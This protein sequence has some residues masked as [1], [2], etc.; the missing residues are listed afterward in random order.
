[1][2]D[3]NLLSILV[4][5]WLSG[6]A[7]AEP[8]SVQHQGLRLNGELQLADGQALGDGVVVL[9]HG[10][11]AHNRME[12]I[13]TLQDLL[14]EAGYNTLSINLSLSEDNRG[15]AM[16]DCASDHRHRLEDAVGE[17]ATWMAWLEASGGGPMVLVAHSLGGNQ[18]ARYALR[19]SSPQLRALV[20]LAPPN[21]DL[22]AMRQRNQ[23]AVEQ[24]SAALERGDPDALQ[25]LPSFLHCPESQVSAASVISYLHGDEGIS[26]PTLIARLGVPT[27]V[28]VGTADALAPGLEVAVQ[29]LVEAGKAELLLV[30]DADHFFR[31]LYAEEAVEAIDEFISEH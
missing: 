21:G 1:M 8:V 27:L 11:L 2:F 28:I 9:V 7:A 31:D 20:L 3:R 5:L 14:V 6:T 15:S 4:L 25:T 12:I 16:F 30:E 29:P 13:A 10:S 22:E 23:A 17:I 24:A 19:H 18:A 26:T